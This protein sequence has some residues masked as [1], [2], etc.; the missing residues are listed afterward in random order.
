[1]IYRFWAYHKKHSAIRMFL[2][3]L[4]AL[5]LGFILLS[6]AGQGIRL[7]KPLP[8]VEEDLQAK[9]LTPRP[10]K[11]LVY[12][13]YGRYPAPKGTVIA[14]D[15]ATAN[16]EKDTYLVWETDPGQHSFEVTFYKM[17]SKNHYKRNVT[18]EANQTHYYFL[19]ME[20]DA[21]GSEET[22]SYKARFVE[23]KEDTGR[24]KIGEYALMAWFR[25]EEVVFRR[26]LEPTPENAQAVAET[27]VPAAE[28]ATEMTADA[29]RELPPVPE[30]APQEMAANPENELVAPA[31]EE[32]AATVKESDETP[33]G[34]Q[35]REYALV[36]GISQYQYLETL[37]SAASDAQA[38][39]DTLRDYGF[40]V[41]TLLDEKA[42]RER[43]LDS[44]E[45]FQRLLEP[46]DKLLIYY[47]GRSVF[48][49][50]GQRAYWQTVDAKEESMTQWLLT[51]NVTA[52]LKQMPA[53]QIFVVADSMYSGTLTRASQAD[54]QNEAA[55][56]RYLEKIVEK[57]S[58]VILTSGAA[59]PSAAMGDSGLSLFASAFV[60]GL[61]EIERDAFVAEELFRGQILEVVA[62]QSD[63]L[64]QFQALRNSGHEGGDFLFVRE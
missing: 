37:P 49:S 6:C 28:P 12:F 13:Y 50:D 1:M 29:V 5:F 20:E 52:A 2:S 33:A 22:T 27:P 36:I 64:P 24:K 19:Y 48:D 8:L 54:L 40:K 62:G 18:T 15:G 14:L 53:T 55:R 51:E 11:S 17:M 9:D 25:D 34:S 32:A 7:S 63:Q 23:A 35:G 4:P 56:Q 59:Q 43:I 30:A 45:V 58:R 38:V 21:L 16:V 3:L 39:A 42:S 61:R 10:G 57:R 46:E 41:N 60:N 26:E 47:T 31:L 44:L